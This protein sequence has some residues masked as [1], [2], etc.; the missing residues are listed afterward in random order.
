MPPTNP[1]LIGILCEALGIDPTGVTAI[2]VTASQGLTPQAT[3]SRDLTDDDGKRISR[4]VS[5]Y[6]LAAK[7]FAT[8]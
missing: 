6:R 4:E 7:A 3:I 5:S 1:P 2:S 8:R